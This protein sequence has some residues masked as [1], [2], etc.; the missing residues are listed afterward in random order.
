MLQNI[1]K[2]CREKVAKGLPKEVRSCLRLQK[3]SMIFKCLGLSLKTLD[4]FLE[5]LYRYIFGLGKNVSVL[6][7]KNLVSEK[8]SWYPYRKKSL[9]ISISQNIGWKQCNYG[10]INV[11]KEIKFSSDPGLLVRSMCLVSLTH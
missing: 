9:G 8:M 11:I 7:S 1:I 5:S 10:A 6:V 3:L 2:S 4:N